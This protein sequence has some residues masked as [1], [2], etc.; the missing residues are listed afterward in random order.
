MVDK[1]KFTEVIIFL[2]YPTF[3]V[4]CLHLFQRKSINDSSLLNFQIAQFSKWIK[5]TQKHATEGKKSTKNVER[6]CDDKDF[7]GFIPKCNHTELHFN[8][9]LPYWNKKPYC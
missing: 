1:G 6:A 3:G 5:C 9:I 7:K 2:A 8:G 4:I